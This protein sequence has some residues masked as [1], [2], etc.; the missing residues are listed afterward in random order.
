MDQDLLQKLLDSD[1]E[2]DVDEWDAK[3]DETFNEDYYKA[4][5]LWSLFK[6]DFCLMCRMKMLNSL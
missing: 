1:N 2:F 5:A 4:L 3:M 6:N